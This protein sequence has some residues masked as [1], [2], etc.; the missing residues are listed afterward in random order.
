MKN[1]LAAGAGGGAGNNSI[2][3]PAIGNSLENILQNDGGAG[4]FPL[5]IS[6][7][8]SLFLILG[9]IL[10]FFYLI[11]GGINYILSGGDKTK[12]EGARHQI[13]YAIFGLVVM[14]SVFA[15][16]SLVETIFNLSILQI[17][18]TQFFIS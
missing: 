2:T 7:L 15:I 11:L 18:I 10:A 6:S 17:D 13:T 14:F 8:V 4:F 12:A 3:N 1:I 5:L 16:V 9:I